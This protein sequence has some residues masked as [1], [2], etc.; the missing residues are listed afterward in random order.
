MD[1]SHYEA[2]AVSLVLGVM[3][4]ALASRNIIKRR[5]VTLSLLFAA[6]VLYFCSIVLLE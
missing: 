1:V 5:D 6:A 2:V 4:L 3:V